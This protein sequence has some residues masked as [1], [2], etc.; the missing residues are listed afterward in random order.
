M[1]DE[2]P[3]GLAGRAWVERLG[4]DL[5]VLQLDAHSD[6]RDEHDGSRWGHARAMRRILDVTPAIVAVGVRALT[7]EERN[8]V[9]ADVVELSPREGTRASDVVAAKAVYKMIGYLTAD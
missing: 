1:T 8:V 7:S 3:P 4:S 2:L 9:A 5:S 6:L